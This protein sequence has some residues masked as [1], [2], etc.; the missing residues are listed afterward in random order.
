MDRNLSKQREICMRLDR[1][2]RVWIW[3]TVVVVDPNGIWLGSLVLFV[4]PEWPF[5]FGRGS[6]TG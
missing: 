6:Q 3:M 5:L 1:A 4:F 2:F